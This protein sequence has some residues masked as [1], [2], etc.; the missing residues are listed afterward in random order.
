[1]SDDIQKINT[2]SGGQNAQNVYGNQVK[3]N[4]YI[5]NQNNQIS[6]NLKIEL[7]YKEGMLNNEKEVLTKL[8]S[9]NNYNFDF[10]ITGLNHIFENKMIINISLKLKM[11]YIG[12]SKLTKD[13]NIK[14]I[15]EFIY[16]VKDIES[17]N[18]LLAKIEEEKL[19]KFIYI[20]TD[21]L[22]DEKIKK[23]KIPDISDLRLALRF[24]RKNVDFDFIEVIGYEFDSKLNINDLINILEKKYNKSIDIL[25]EVRNLN[26]D[27]LELFF[28]FEDSVDWTIDNLYNWLRE[29]DELQL[30][31]SNLKEVQAK[32]INDLF[33]FALKGYF[34]DEDINEWIKLKNYYLEFFDKQI[35]RSK[36]N[37]SNM[38][39]KEFINKLYSISDEITYKLVNM[40][41]TLK[42]LKTY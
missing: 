29:D 23:N 34:K 7:Q 37:S 36:I 33:D 28:D 38:S 39:S 27:T 35:I 3:T 15:R 1:M 11:K 26:K 22:K 17:L 30:V 19:N 9:L 18:N 2:I 40:E 16:K 24:Y 12:K 41:K 4:I 20:L 32:T 21:F 42:E 25:K 31:K 10:I 6:Q 5:E 13:W 8:F 14:N